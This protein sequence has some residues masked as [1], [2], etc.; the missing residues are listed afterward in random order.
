MQAA[1]IVNGLEIQATYRDS[2]VEDIFRPMVRHWAELQRERGGR[3]IVLMAAAPG[4]GKS[5]LALFLSHLAEEMQ[6]GVTIQ[7]IG[8]DGYHYPNAY[9]DAHTYVEDGEE[10][11][12]RSRKGAFFTY[13]VSGLR[14][15]LIDAHSEHP[16]AWPTYS[17]VAHDVLPDSLEVTGDI[18]LVEGNYFLLNEGEWV[19]ID[20][21]ADETVF[22]FADE[23]LLHER[24]VDRKIKGGSTPEE[25]EAWY[26]QSDGKNVAKVLAHHKPAN[27]ELK[28]DRDGNYELV[29][30]Q[31]LLEG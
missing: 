17:R 24:L 10:V 30:G 21:L 22:V 7:P 26:L 23:R 3:L 29:C 8:M 18:L 27:F 9:L 2:D 13:D 25:G 16:K 19:G 12:L 4:T 20:E 31:E 28:M 6:L 5:T 11:T 1:L 15:K 14:E